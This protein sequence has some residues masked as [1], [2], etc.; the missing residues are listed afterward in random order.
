MKKFEGT[1]NLITTTS[2][3]KQTLA[4]PNGKQVQALANE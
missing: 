3:G 2:F 1:E 4:Q